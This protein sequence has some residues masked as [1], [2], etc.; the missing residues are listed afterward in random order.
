VLDVQPFQKAHKPAHQ[1]TIDFGPYG[2][3]HSSAQVTALY[4]PRD[5]LHK[6]VIAVTNFPPKQIAN[7]F[8]EC[9]VLGVVGAGGEV[10]L[11]RPERD[12]DNGLR[13]G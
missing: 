10:V 9:L 3:R 12:V 13:I 6:Q 11:L 8:S 4:Q 7:F 1:L 2:K 5:L